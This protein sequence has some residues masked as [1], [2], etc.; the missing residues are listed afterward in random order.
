MAIHGILCSSSAA[1]MGS[2]EIHLGPLK[3]NVPSLHPFHASKSGPEAWIPM[4][5]LR[6][7][8]HFVLGVQ[9]VVV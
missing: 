9:S 4:A 5:C 3:K 1:N 2:S 7:A 6:T 8:G